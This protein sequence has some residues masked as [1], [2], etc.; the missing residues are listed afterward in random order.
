MC[1]ERKECTVI[2]ISGNFN[3]LTV[4]VVDFDGMAMIASK[5]LIVP[6]LVNFGPYWQWQ[7]KI[8]VL[9][10]FGSLVP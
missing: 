7:E 9:R 6:G 1:T 2:K 10:A 3:L 8:G 4:F 5:K